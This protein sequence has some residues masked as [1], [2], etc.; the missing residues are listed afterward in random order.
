M[1]D[2]GFYCYKV[3]PFGFKNACAMYQGL[4][5]KMFANQIRNSMEM[6]VND[7]LVMSRKARRHVEDLSE[8]FQVLRQYGMKLNKE[9]CLSGISS[10]K[11]LCYIVSARGIEANPAKIADLK[12]MKARKT[13]KQLKSLTGSV[14]A[15]SR[16]I[17]KSTDKRLPFFNIIK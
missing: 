2:Q 6:Y 13:M 15:L 1:T 17:L 12:S 8:M 7:M 14:A 10:G 4:V 16:F 9:K 11:F 5:N 3:M